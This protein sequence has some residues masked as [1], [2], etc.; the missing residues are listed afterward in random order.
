MKASISYTDLQ[1]LLLLY[2]ARHLLR[3]LLL[4][5]SKG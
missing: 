2:K 1:L 3:L 4:L 5:Q